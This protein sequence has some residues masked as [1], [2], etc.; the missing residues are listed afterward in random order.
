[1]AIKHVPVVGAKGASATLAMSVPGIDDGSYISIYPLLQL[2]Q[3]TLFLLL[4]N[5][6]SL[7]PTIPSFS[8]ITVLIDFLTIIK[9]RK[10]DIN[11]IMR[12]R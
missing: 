2:Y 1:M 9:Y 7:L 4:S 3:K 12:I 5:E 6:V 11:K 8:F 10:K